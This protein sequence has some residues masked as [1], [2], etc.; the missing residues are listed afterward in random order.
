[1]NGFCHKDK[2]ES[3][4]SCETRIRALKLKYPLE[5]YECRICPPG[6]WHRTKNVTRVERMSRHDREWLKFILAP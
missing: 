6:T 5:A 2:Y 4:E 3:K 1:M